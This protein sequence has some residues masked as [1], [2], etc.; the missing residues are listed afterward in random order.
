MEKEHIVLIVVLMIVVGLLLYAFSDFLK[1]QEQEE[2]KIQQ[3]GLPEII[4]GT[5]ESGDV[6][7]SLQ[8]REISGG[9]INFFIEVNTHSVDLSKFDLKEL[10]TLE[11]EGKSINPSSAP[12]LS[13]HHAS[14]ILV[15][16]AEAKEFRVVVRGIPKVEERVFS[17]DKSKL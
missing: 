17:W 6:A 14:G 15:F 4:T 9:K 12:A 13:G 7:I 5:T 11:Y 16:D 1:S 2:K 10:A 3:E 8:P